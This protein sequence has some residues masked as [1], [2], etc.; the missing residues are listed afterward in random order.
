M[1]RRMILIILLLGLPSASHADTPAPAAKEV[2]ATPA[3]GFKTLAF[4]VDNTE[5]GLKA[6]RMPGVR[7]SET[8][9]IEQ[10]PERE[11]AR[12]PW[13]AAGMIIASLMLVAFMARRD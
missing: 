5:F 6:T 7:P 12:S 1:L 4:E 10:H 8:P 9:S 2:E 11:S 13:K 3:N